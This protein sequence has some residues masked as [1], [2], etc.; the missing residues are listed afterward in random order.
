M[1]ALATV[2]RVALVAIA[3]TTPLAA[4]CCKHDGTSPPGGPVPATIRVRSIALDIGEHVPLDYT[5]LDSG[6]APMPNYPV[7]FRV[8]RPELAG[9]SSDG[10]VSGLSY[11]ATTVSLTA[12]AVTQSTALQVSPWPNEPPGFRVVTER[13]F[14]RLA[15]AANDSVGLQG[16]DAHT[17]YQFSHY[18]IVAS[19]DAPRSPPS[20]LQAL[21]P[22]GTRGGSDDATPGSA[23]RWFDA[24][25]RVYVSVWVQLSPNWQAHSTG[26]NKV[27]FV[28]IDGQPRFFLSAEGSSSAALLPA[29]RLQG[30]PDDV[31]RNR[32]R[33]LPNVQASARVVPGTWQR[34]EML[35]VANTPGQRDGEFHLWMDGIEVTRDTD[36]EY[37]A[38][39]EARAW[40]M[41]DVRPIWGGGGDVLA[42][43]QWMRFDHIYIST[44]GL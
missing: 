7:Q 19:P 44:G 29:G 18:S 43:T 30:T 28:I 20:V 6:G 15:T 8:A 42:S 34:W 26:T 14:S 32:A 10:V 21:Y 36:V 13:D 24:A 4:L 12:G 27:L 41:L 16:W 22:A 31:L 9:V 5:V 25:P 35:L 1:T 17:E 23:Q 39:G 11:G 2:R 38:A 37:V 33:L 3:T 40:T